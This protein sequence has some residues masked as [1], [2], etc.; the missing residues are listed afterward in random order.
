MASR[1]ALFGGTFDPIHH[2]HLISARAIAEALSLDRMVLIPSANPPH[3]LTHGVTDAAD[4]LAM[5]ELA[6]ADVEGFEASDCEMARSGP[7]FTVETVASYRQQLGDSCE[8]FWVIGGT[9]TY[10]R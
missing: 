4:R 7:S 3:K 2:G 9:G 5:V 8:L 1:V 6:I 10:P